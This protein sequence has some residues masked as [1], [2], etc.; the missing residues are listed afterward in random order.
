MDVKLIEP[1]QGRK[2]GHVFGDEMTDGVKNFL[3]ERLQVGKYVERSPGPS[4]SRNASSVRTVDGGGGKKARRNS[5]K[6]YN[7]R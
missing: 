5:R 2:A 7:A 3:V 1:W 4:S 6:R